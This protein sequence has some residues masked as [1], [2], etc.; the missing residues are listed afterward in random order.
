MLKVKQKQ[1][2]VLVTFLFGKVKCV[3]ES[4]LIDHIKVL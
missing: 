1:G 3:Y 4:K 2:E